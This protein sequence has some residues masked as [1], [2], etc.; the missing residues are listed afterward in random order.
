MKRI[1][2]VIVLT[3]LGTISA[4]APTHGQEPVLR[5]ERGEYADQIDEDIETKIVNNLQL[6]EPR[7]TVINLKPSSERGQRLLGLDRGPLRVKVSIEYMK[8]R[9]DA[10]N[11]VRFHL[12]TFQAHPFR[13]LDRLGDEGYALTENGFL[14]F[15]VDMIVVE[16][17]SSDRSIETQTSIAQRVKSCVQARPNKS[18]H[19]SRGSVFLMMPLLN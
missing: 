6:L 18:L 17:D 2:L 7:W 19:A 13:K 1:A 16:I 14:L 8:T 11:E 4:L 3:S 10:A 15:R 9:E 5:V 12:H